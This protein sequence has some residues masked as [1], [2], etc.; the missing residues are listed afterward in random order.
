[1][2]ASESP[3][4]DGKG[5][6]ILVEDDAIVRMISA[7]LLRD[8]A[9]EVAEVASG[10]EALSVLESQPADILITD[11]NL[12]GMSGDDLVRAARRLCPKISVILA[13]GDVSKT[14]VDPANPVYLLQK[15]YDVRDLAKATA[16]VKPA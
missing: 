2:T 7:E 1:L 14:P 6:V 12:P 8:M 4:S 15:P 9:Y 13:S 16:A 10:E 5:F 11:L 3:A